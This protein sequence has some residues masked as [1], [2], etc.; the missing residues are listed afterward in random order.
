MLAVLH[1]VERDRR[2]QLPGRR[3]VDEVEVERIFARL[4]KSEPAK[5]RNIKR[6]CG[7]N[8]KDY[9]CSDF[10][11]IADYIAEG[12]PV[13]MYGAAGCGKSHTAEQVAKELSL[14]YY[15]QSQVLFA[16]D[17]KG[18]GVWLQ[19]IYFLYSKINIY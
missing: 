9:R 5:V 3:D 1:L 7:S 10:D 6:N 16:H 18:Y 17:I 19:Q 13:Y 11:E 14:D 4:A 2:M 8:N 15:T 12:Q